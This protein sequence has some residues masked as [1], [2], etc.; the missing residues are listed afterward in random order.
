MKSGEG[1]SPGMARVPVLW[2]G[3]LRR[4]VRHFPLG[5]RWTSGCVKPPTLHGRGW[6]RGSPRYQ[7]SQGD[8]LSPGH[9]EQGRRRE[10][11]TQ[12]RVLSSDCGWSTGRPSDGRIGMA[13]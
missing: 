8:T 13:C 4:I 2:A 5:P 11:P 9:R 7:G 12:A 10:V 1:E 3:G 6:T